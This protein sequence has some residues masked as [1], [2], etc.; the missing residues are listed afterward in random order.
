V[1]G[2]A[3]LD[4][5]RAESF[6]DDAETY[7]S[8][9]P[10]YPEQ[11]VDDLMA[12]HPVDVLD[13]GCGTGI[14]S[15]LFVPRSCRVLGV[16]ADPRMAEVARRRGLDVEVSRFE[17]WDPA[18]R[19]FDLLV[20]GQAW[21]WVD[22]VAGAGA[23]VRALR[24]GGRFAAFWN[25]HVHSP[26][27]LALMLPAYEAEAPELVEFSV[28]LGT[29]RDA[30]PQDPLRDPVIVALMDAGEFGSPERRIYQWERAY[31]VDEWLRYVGTGSD[32]HR[33]EPGRLERLIGALKK[34]LLVRG[35]VFTVGYETE[36]L[37]AVR[38]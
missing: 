8:V 23:A 3:H 19:A 21:H 32:H 5:G 25:E 9:R 4:R 33:L 35:E 7:D 1:A 17:D 36:L 15:R 26:E 11:L 31:H 38:G 16:E 6:G 14:V 24:G 30:I 27:S 18:G 29:I 28:V 13:V 12:E 20:S 34:A 37:T 2:E 22:P 10:S